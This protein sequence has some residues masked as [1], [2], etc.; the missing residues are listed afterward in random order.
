MQENE[1]LVTTET[2]IRINREHKD[3]L[4]RLI[5]GKEEYKQNLLELYNALNDTSYNNLDDLKI[6]TIED[7]VYMGM[8]NDV[9]M[10][11]HSRMTL[12]EHQST[13]NPNMPIRGFMYAARLYNKYIEEN[14][15]NIYSKTK[16]KLPTPQYIVFY[17]GDE[18]HEDEEILRL[19]D[20]F[21]TAEKTE[22]YEWT[23][24]MLNINYGRNK[25][26]MEKCKPLRDYAILIDKIKRYTAEKK[27][28]EEAVNQAVDECIK[29]DVLADFL[30]KHRAEVMDVCITEYDEKRVMDAIREEEREEGRKEGRKEGYGEGCAREKVQAVENVMTSLNVSAEEAC[31]I[32][33]YLLEDYEAAKALV[34]N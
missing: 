34:E 19:S 14:N 29:E 9:S 25:K 20:A 28:I 1:R 16:M 30:R 5:F 3:R 7:V 2:E 12:F 18:K 23:A 10:L 8:K 11:I 21:A 15:L 13:Y 17:N 33:Q 6:T 32:L 26:L 27:S 22:G 31:K 24:R 4:F